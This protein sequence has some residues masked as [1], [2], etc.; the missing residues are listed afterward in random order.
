MS[1][2]FITLIFGFLLGKFTS[3]R[4]HFIKESNYKRQQEVTHRPQITQN[5]VDILISSVIN[6][7]QEKLST[8]SFKEQYFKEDGAKNFVSSLGGNFTT[9]LNEFSF[10][11]NE[12][13]LEDFLKHLLENSYKL[14]VK[15]VKELRSNLLNE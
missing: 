10:D 6:A 3:D 15:C 9:C 13:D 14:Y 4:N 11:H 7:A 8:N 5:E 12:E 2:A 1:I